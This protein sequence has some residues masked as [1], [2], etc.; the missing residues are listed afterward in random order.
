M[1]RNECISCLHLQ[2]EN[3]WINRTL[4]DPRPCQTSNVPLQTLNPKLSTKG[5]LS[6]ARFVNV[7][8][9]MSNVMYNTCKCNYYVINI[10]LTFPDDWV[11]LDLVRNVRPI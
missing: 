3:P 1:N 8:Q 11:F 7:M 6:N 4:Y 9:G 10:L 2:G 5:M